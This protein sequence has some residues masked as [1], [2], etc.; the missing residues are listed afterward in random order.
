MRRI[1]VDRVMDPMRFFVDGDP[2]AQ[3]TGQNEMTEWTFDFPDVKE[4]GFELEGGL[5][6]A[7]LE[8]CF[9]PKRPYFENDSVRIK[10]L[11]EIHLVTTGMLPHL[12]L[13]KTVSCNLDLLQFYD[14]EEILG[15]FFWKDGAY[16]VSMLYGEDAIVHDAALRLEQWDGSAGELRASV[17]IVVQDQEGV[18]RFSWCMAMEA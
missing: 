6:V 17:R 2:E 9:T 8:L 15:A 5:D 4:S 3:P 18:S 7:R 1:L 12:E 10:A 13:D 11:P 14:G 16:H